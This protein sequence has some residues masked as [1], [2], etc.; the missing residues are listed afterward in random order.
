[1]C[2]QETVPVMSASNATQALVVHRIHRS[3]AKARHER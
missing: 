3:A 1:M 2:K